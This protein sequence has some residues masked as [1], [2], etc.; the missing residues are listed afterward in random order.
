MQTTC[1]Q[2]ESET[3]GEI[4]LEDDICHLHV[5][6][7]SSA[8]RADDKRQQLCIKPTSFLVKLFVKISWL[9]FLIWGVTSQYSRKKMPRGEACPII[10][11]ALLRVSS[12]F[13]PRP[14][15]RSF[16]V[17][18]R[19]FCVLSPSQ[20]EMFVFPWGIKEIKAAQSR[21]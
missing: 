11:R 12:A 13:L 3:L 19:L 18:L 2:H 10:L 21:A 8:H 9:P 15:Q 1:R 5:V 7:T 6:R 20:P 17:S 16:H 14:F 4:S